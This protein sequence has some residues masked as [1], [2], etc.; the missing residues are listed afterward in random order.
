MRPEDFE[1]PALLRQILAPR[2]TTRQTLAVATLFAL[3][4][5]IC[6][7]VLSIAY[8]MAHV[9]AVTWAI[10]S[11]IL[12]LQPGIQQS[13]SASAV[14]ILANLIG[15]TV[16][17][18][19]GRAFG[20][21]AWQVPVAL[22]IVAYVCEGLRL[23]LGLRTACVSVVIVMLANEGRVATSSVERLAAVL[24]GCAFAV[25]LQLLFD[26]ARR[27]L[28]RATTAPPA[29]QSDADHGQE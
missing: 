7:V 28:G 25:V 20:P 21:G 14:R 12:V 15:A 22:V 24:I 23:D 2:Q 27:W 10:V 5:V 1:R 13:I 8:R 6:T 26:R 18:I 29:H 9:S 19:V 11:A 16:G 4:A 3:Q 17:F